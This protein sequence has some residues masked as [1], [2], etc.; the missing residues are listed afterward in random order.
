MPCDDIFT[1][2]EDNHRTLWLST[3]CG[4]AALRRAE[5]DRW[6]EDNTSKLHVDVFDRFDGARPGTSAEPTQPSSTK[7]P[8]GRLWFANQVA[9]QMIDPNQLYTNRVLPPVHIEKL[10][11][12]H[13]D[14]ELGSEIDLPALT[15]DVE[16]DYSALSLSV[17]QKVLF[18]YRL[19]GRDNTWQDAVM[20]R[21]AFYT[22]LPPGQ[23]RFRVIA[24]N[25]SGMWN[26]AGAFLDFSIAPA[27][28]QTNW[29]RALW[30]AAFLALL[31]AG[32]SSA[33]SATEERRKKVSAKQLRPCLP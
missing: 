15:R 29:F 25:N 13:K 9:V 28:Y 10:A 6:G 17:P 20:R 5:L 3:R 7:S 8:D 14:Y 33:G 23:Y 21:Q 18:R 1:A 31:W 2:I 26:E 27:Y 30:A 22:N 32:L 19:E 16:V 4:Y 24:C 12:D 11:A